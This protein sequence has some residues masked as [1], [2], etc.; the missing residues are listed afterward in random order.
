[1]GDEQKDFN[2]NYTMFVLLGAF[3]SIRQQK[4]QRAKSKSL[5]FTANYDPADNKDAVDQVKDCFYEDLTL[6]DMIDYGM[7]EELAG[8]MVQVVNFHKLPEDTMLELIRYKVGIISSD[9]EIDIEMT[10]DSMKS[11]LDI[12][13]GSLGVRRPL[14]RIRELA[15]NT[16][17]E[18]F[19]E[20][21]FDS[22]RDRVV[23]DSQ[24]SAHIE[25][26]VHRKEYDR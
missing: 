7:R 3:Q 13:F 24:D 2:S 5:G 17:A 23:I 22:S 15:Q 1:F 18:V 26:R 10:E 8:R 11:F 12:S 19:F 9:M 6:Q 20:G 25:R 21:R 16:V 14:N 4:Q